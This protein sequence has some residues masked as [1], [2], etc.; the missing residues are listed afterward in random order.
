MNKSGAAVFSEAAPLGMRPG[1]RAPV[2][3][4]CIIKAD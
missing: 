2:S 4:V 1:G 3:A